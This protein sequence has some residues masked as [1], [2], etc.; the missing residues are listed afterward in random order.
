MSECVGDKLS[1]KSD[2][3]IIIDDQIKAISISECEKKSKLNVKISN[4][5]GKIKKVRKAIEG[6][7]STSQDR[8]SPDGPQWTLTKVKRTGYPEG[9]SIGAKFAGM[10]GK[11][12]KYYLLDGQQENGNGWGVINSSIKQYIGSFINKPFVITSNEWIPDSE[13]EEQ[14]DHPFIPTNNMQAILRHQEKFRVG[15][16]VKVTQDGEN[17]RWYAMIKIDPK[18]A[19]M[20][21]PPFCSPALYQIDPHEDEGSISIWEGLHLAGL[22]SDPAYGPR[23][24][25]LKG[26]CTGQAGQCMHQFRMAKQAQGDDTIAPIKQQ[27]QSGVSSTMCDCEEDKFEKKVAVLKI[28]ISKLRKKTKLAKDF[29]ESEHPRNE[30]GSLQLVEVQKK[31]LI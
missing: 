25:L 5:R 10:D 29:K 2:K 13:Y 12:A 11:F 21:L 1:E 9:F 3:D 26:S 23:I 14:Y 4:I 30:G 27:G 7:I 22:D 15:N 20:P 19:H 16:I 24:A 31:I 17:G 6:S 28:K 8:Q 18:F